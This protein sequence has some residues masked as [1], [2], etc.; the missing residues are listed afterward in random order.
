MQNGNNVR[1]LIDAEQSFLQ[2]AIECIAEQIQAKYNQQRPYA[3]NTLQNYL[4][5][6]EERANYEL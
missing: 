3:I 1:V 6:A 4:K 2:R 5:I